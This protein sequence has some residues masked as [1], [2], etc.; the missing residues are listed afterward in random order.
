MI[1]KCTYKYLIMLA[2]H[3]WL[4]NSRGNDQGFDVQ[5][6]IPPT[7][8]KDLISKTLNTKRDLESAA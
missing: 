5:D 8:E 3:Q 1:P 4:S 7:P 2:R 6:Q